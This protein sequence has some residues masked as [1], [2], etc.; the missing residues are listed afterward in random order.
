MKKENFK[1]MTKTPRDVIILHK[2]IKNHD[3]MQYCVPKIWH[4]MDL[5]VIFHFCLF[6]ALLPP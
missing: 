4:M 1:K 3:H 2:C 6:F 5:I